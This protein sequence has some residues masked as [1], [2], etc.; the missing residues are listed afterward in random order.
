MGLYL[1]K[2]GLATVWEK[3]KSRDTDTLTAA[4]NYADS[5]DT[6]LQSTLN[7]SITSVNSKVTTLQGY[8][9]SG[10]AKKATGDKNGND[11]TTTY[12]KASTKGVAN[13]VAS[14]DSDGKVPSAQ[15]PSYV[16]DII[17]GYY[18]A[19]DTTSKFWA[20]KSTSSSRIT[21]ETGKIY[22]DK[23]TGITYRF[24]GTDFVEISSSL[25]LGETSSTAYAGNKGKTNATNIATLQGY[26][27]SG[28]AKKATADK[29]GNDITTT[30]ST[31]ANTIK[32]LSI[33][34][35]TITYT[36]GDSTTGT[37][38]TQD[39]V[40]TLP[41]ATSSTLGGV[42]IGSNISVS[43]GTISLSK[44]NVTSALGYTPPTTNTTYSVA[45][46]SANGLMSSIDKAKLDGI[47]I[48]SGETYSEATSGNIPTK[49]SIATYVAKTI[50]STVTAIT[51]TEINDIC[52]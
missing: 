43:S 52:V 36:K 42:K 35:K 46:T 10:I 11:I 34:G 29:N 20:D 40:Y 47:T 19:S 31:L 26:F 32:S 15:L 13:G 8:F 50:S 27:A 6:T 51:E 5:Q 22:V 24:S 7:T 17:E 38:T 49:G 2:T 14:L 33:S 41:N 18:M 39:T 16:D 9:S 45:T 1:D 44:S 37:L 12:I 28:V 30:Y 23:D 3:V 48:D 21:G 25:A 4:K